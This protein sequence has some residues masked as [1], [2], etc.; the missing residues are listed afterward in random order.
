MG[1][2][3]T[4]QDE[5]CETEAES[6]PLPWS[7][8]PSE[9]KDSSAGERGV[10]PTPCLWIKMSFPNSFIYDRR[11][12]GG[13]SQGASIPSFISLSE[14]L[15]HMCNFGHMSSVGRNQDRAS[16]EA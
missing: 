12:P 8:G 6:F 11:V 3:G 5:G 16:G 10:P 9:A 13:S 14:I 15:S 4:S 1:Q 2:G 7:Q